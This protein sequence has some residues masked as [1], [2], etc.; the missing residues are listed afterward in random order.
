MNT[1]FRLFCLLFVLMLAGDFAYA[2]GPG[3]TPPKGGN[4]ECPPCAGGGQHSGGSKG[5]R[6]GNI[7]SERGEFFQYETD[8]TIPGRVACKPSME[9][10]FQREYR[11]QINTNGPL[12]RNWNHNYFERLILQADGSVQHDNGLDRRGDRYRPDGAEDFIS[13]PEFFTGLNKNPDDSFTLRFH[14]GSSKHFDAEGKLIKLR[15]RNDNFMTFHYDA[16][17]R[18]ARVNDTL[19]RDI[20]YRYLTTPGVNNGRLAEIEDFIGRKVKFSYDIRG[21]LVEVT[22]PAVTGTPNG[23]DFPQGKTTRYTYSSGFADFNLNHNLLTVTRPNEVDAGGPPVLINE[24]GA[25]P[26]AFDF[27][28][29]ISQTYGGTNISGIPAGGMFTYTYTQLIPPPHT[30]NPNL[31]VSR[32]RETDRNGNIE[33][34]E[35]NL[36]GYPLVR[37]EFTNRDIRPWRSR[38]V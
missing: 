1:F 38:N 28:K 15:D 10:S 20:V 25:T 37:R 30:L 17:G 33:E 12:G 18:L 14:N 35:Y 27:D 34:Y 26:G 4:C 16:D 24:Y 5:G 22:S 23:N 6:S 13:P 31:I 32:T 29:V 21:D 11:A 19:G 7:Y 8:L 2:K 3:K 9:Y 36:L